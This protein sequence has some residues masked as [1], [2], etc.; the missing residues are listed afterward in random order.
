MVPPNVQIALRKLLTDNNAGEVALGLK[1][2][3]AL[4]PPELAMLLDL[5]KQ[6]AERHPDRLTA[7]GVLHKLAVQKVTGAGAKLIETARSIPPDSLKPSVPQNIAEIGQIEPMLRD[8]AVTVLKELATHSATKAGKAAPK[9]LE[10]LQKK[11]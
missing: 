8:A 11:N 4:P 2:A 3:P 10:S 5:L 1:L 7:V 6:D 9:A